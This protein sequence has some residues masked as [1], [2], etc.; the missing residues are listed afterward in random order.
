MIK[1]TRLNGLVFY[2]D[3]EK[4]ESLE[5]TPDTVITLVGGKTVMV[6]ERVDMVVRR[7]IRYR[8]HVHAPFSRPR[9]DRAE[10]PE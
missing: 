9:R 6:K 1:L 8:R 10:P 4:V 2:L 7:I 5:A 3:A